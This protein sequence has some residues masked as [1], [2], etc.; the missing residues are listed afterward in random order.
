VRDNV[1]YTKEQ[2][3]RS[4]FLYAKKYKE[5]LL[6]KKAIII[7]RER[8]DLKIHFIEV[9]FLK[10]NFQHL[11]GVD[12]VDGKGNII[13]GQSENFFRKCIQQ[14]LSVRE[15]A[16]KTDGTT[17]L[18]L[19]ALPVLM[20][21]NRVTKI[22]GDYNGLR[23]YLVVDKLI[24]GVNFCLGLRLDTNCGD[25]VPVSALNT[26]IR[27]LSVNTSQV[28]AIFLKDKKSEI[29]RDI[30]Y[31]AKGLNLEKI[32]LPQEIEQVISLENYKCK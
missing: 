5:K 18:K 8:T 21:L 4:L 15:I 13:K 16:F 19:D 14:K 2:A 25:Y 10:R 32:E 30:K 1:K 9:L 26:D 3:V 28:L 29:Y 27:D 12:L 24:G 17:H 31:I 11:T 6:N 22:V 23:P 20:E 7:Y